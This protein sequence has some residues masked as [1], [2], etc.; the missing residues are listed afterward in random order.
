[1]PMV[2]R[3]CEMKYRYSVTWFGSETRPA[4]QTFDTQHGRA[5]LSLDGTIALFDGQPSRTAVKELPAP[6]LVYLVQRGL[7]TPKV[8]AGGLA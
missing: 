6:K 3:T 5:K 7:G 2:F 8:R 1:M 4:L